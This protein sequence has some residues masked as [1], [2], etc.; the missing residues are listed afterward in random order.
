MLDEGTAHNANSASAN[1]EANA[2]SG[3]PAHHSTDPDPRPTAYRTRSGFITWK[4][5]TSAR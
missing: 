5:T 2:A 4:R 1:R 3:A